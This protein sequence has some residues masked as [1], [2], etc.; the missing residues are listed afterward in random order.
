MKEIIKS[1]YGLELECNSEREIQER[2]EWVE[3]MEKE[4]LKPPHL[5]GRLPEL[6]FYID[7]DFTL[8]AE[9]YYP[10]EIDER[11]DDGGEFLWEN[12]CKL[13]SK[14]AASHVYVQ[15]NWADCYESEIM[16]RCNGYVNKE[17]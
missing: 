7:A 14:R 5:R 2:A 15:T 6:K 1:Y 16:G 4:A 10:D 3:H 8:Q 13:K 9:E 11:Q 17:L 12:E